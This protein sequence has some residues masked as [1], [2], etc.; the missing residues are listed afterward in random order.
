MNPQPTI[1]RLVE[2][3][4]RRLP[5]SVSAIRDEF[6]DGARAILADAFARM[7]VVSR[8]EFDAQR[9]VLARTRERI[10][11][12][13]QALADLQVRLAEMEDSPR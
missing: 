5:D 1:D 13:E 10:E 7:D 12:L 6:A 2:E 9:L 4:G 3:L 11:A 8:D